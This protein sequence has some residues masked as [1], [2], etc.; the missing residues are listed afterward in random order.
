MIPRTGIPELADYGRLAM[1]D[2]AR[3]HYRY[4]LVMTNIAM[5]AMDLGNRWFTYKKWLDLS[6]AMLNNQSL[7]G[8]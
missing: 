2:I 4:P 3:Q 1:L 5:E 7:Y 8:I 6:M